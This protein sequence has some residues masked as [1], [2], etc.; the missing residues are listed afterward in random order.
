MCFF[1]GDCGS[2]AMAGINFCFFGEGKE[3]LHM[4]MVTNE[5]VD[6]TDPIQVMWALA[7]RV[8]PE[9]D[10]W[11][12]PKTHI[13]PIMTWPTPEER[14]KRVGAKVFF[15]ATWPLDWPSDWVPKVAS[16]KESWPKEIQDKVLTS[17]KEYGFQ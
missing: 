13:S 8:H 14:V 1:S 6:V 15:D 4:V 17:W 7:T 10:I 3:F 9:R 12:L 2:R 11:V 16:F 5:D